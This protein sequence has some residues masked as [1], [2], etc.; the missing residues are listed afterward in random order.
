[1]YFIR[2]FRYSLFVVIVVNQLFS[3]LSVLSR[4]FLVT[5]EVATK[6]T[7]VSRI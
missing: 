5:A 1:M 7:L 2:I 3:K 4:S 6:L